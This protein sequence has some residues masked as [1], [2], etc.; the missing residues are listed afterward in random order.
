LCALLLI[1]EGIRD[2]MKPAGERQSITAALPRQTLLIFLGVAGAI[3][4]YFLLFRPLGFV[5]DTAL[6][7]FIAMALTNRGKWVT[8]TIVAL[9]IPVVFYAVLGG[10]FRVPLPRGILTFW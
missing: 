1:G 4:L 2:R 5:V 8:N 3:A 9:A 7:L 10:I 6:F